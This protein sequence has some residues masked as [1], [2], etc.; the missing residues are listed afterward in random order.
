MMNESVCENA[1]EKTVKGR[2]YKNQHIEKGSQ[3]H[4]NKCGRNV[5]SGR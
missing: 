1:E 2:V 3:S 5:L 4:G